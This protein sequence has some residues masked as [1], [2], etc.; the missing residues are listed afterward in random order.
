MSF[1]N[2]V[3][4]EIVQQPITKSSLA[5]LSALIKTHGTFKISNNGFT[6]HVQNENILVIRQIVKLLKYFFELDLEIVAI[7]NMKFGKKNIFA[8]RILNGVDD[9][10]K[11]LQLKDKTGFLT[12]PNQSFFKNDKQIREYLKGI[13][14]G[15]GSINSPE[16]TNYHL[17]FRL[18]GEVF[19]LF[20]MEL[21]K[22]IF[23]EAKFIK[24][25]EQY[26]VYVKASEQIGD[27]L[28]AIEASNCLMKFEDMRIR[29]DFKNSLTRLDNCT[30]ANDMKTYI[31]GNKQVNEIEILQQNGMFETLDEKLK[32]VALLRLAYPEESLN[33]L[34]QLY[35]EQYQLPITK[36]GL[37][38]RFRKISTLAKN[39]KHP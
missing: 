31:T 9:L 24:R 22:S 13:F 4:Q 21:L 28:R 6:I 38:H 39:K 20:V 37:A 8:I 10:L 17:E 25:R 19:A 34:V 29:R 23:I 27:F 12:Y 2:E 26:V 11:S 1:T 15:C 36:S 14:L 3:K 33:D 16:N 32:Q 5:Q 35:Y 7:K 30:T 18:D